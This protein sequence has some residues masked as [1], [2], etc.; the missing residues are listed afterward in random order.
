MGR[1]LKRENEKVVKWLVGIVIEKRCRSKRR[2]W[3][4][5]MV[6]NEGKE[7]R[8]RQMKSDEVYMAWKNANKEK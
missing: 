1:F 8:E 4:G 3:K 5:S 2:S 7:T 6:C